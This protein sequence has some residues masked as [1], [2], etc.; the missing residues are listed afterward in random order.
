MAGETKGSVR[1]DGNL[2]MIGFQNHPAKT[3]QYFPKDPITLSDN[4]Q[5]VY[6]HLR[7]AMYIFVY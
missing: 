5:G 2:K 1:S 4:E 6:N 7:K 3:Y